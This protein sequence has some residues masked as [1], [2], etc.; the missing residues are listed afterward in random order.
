M[1]AF[2]KSLS[3]SYYA[4]TLAIF[5][6][7]MCR[8]LEML[9]FV[10]PA[11]M[12]IAFSVVLF[13]GMLRFLNF[14]SSRYI[15]AGLIVVTTVLRFGQSYFSGTAFVTTKLLIDIGLIFY[16]L[17]LVMR[18]LF[19]AEEADKDTVFGGVVAYLLMGIGFAVVYGLIEFLEPGSFTIA[20]EVLRDSDNAM[21][22]LL[23]YSF[24]TI[25]TLGYGDA[26]PV[27]DTARSITSIEA[28]AGQMLIAIIIARIVSLQ[29]ASYLA[30]KD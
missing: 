8:P 26:L 2:F 10:G 22:D 19:N 6:L 17:W 21:G 1:G 3:N 16:F 30:K 20:G 7:V 13:L 23:Y 28:V 27:T 14:K 25:T 9:P 29:T 24:V 5:F 15:L 4:L 18:D 12:S 11:V